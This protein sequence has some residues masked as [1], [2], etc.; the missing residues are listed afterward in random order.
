MNIA[1][2][3]TSIESLYEDRC[4]IYEL[5]S[6]QDPETKIT[7][8]TEQEVATDQP[9]RLSFQKLSAAL[10]SPPGAVVGQ[11]IKLFL[12]PDITVKPGSKIAVTRNGSIMQ[13]IS[14]GL[15]AVYSTHQEILLQAKGWA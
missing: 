10:D 4:T 13:F 7:N 1:A 2:V 5:A 8:Q 14:S 6:I 9:C 3:R 11:T 15:P 12:S